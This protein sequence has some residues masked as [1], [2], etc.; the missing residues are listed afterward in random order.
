[1]TAAEACTLLVEQTIATAAARREAQA[2]RDETLN[3]RLFV[4]VVLATIPH[5]Q[6]EQRHG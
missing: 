3:C 5:S 4:L 2:A 1:M 6:D